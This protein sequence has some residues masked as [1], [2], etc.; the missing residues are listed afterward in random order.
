MDTTSL[1]CDEVW[2]STPTPD[3]LNYNDNIPPKTD[4]SAEYSSTQVSEVDFLICLEKEELY[5]PKKGFLNYLQ[6]QNLIFS[7]FRAI[8]WLIKTCTRFNLSLV[9]LFNAANYLDR[10]ISINHCHEWK[11]WMM[12]LL[13]VACLSVAAKFSETSLPSLHEI[14][15]E[16]L[17]HT[18]EPITIQQMELILL[19]TL[20]WRLSSTTSYSFLELLMTMK[21]DDLFQSSLLKDLL[22]DRVTQLLLQTILDYKMVE[23]RPSIAAISAMW[24]GMEELMPSQSQAYLTHITGFFNHIHKDEIVK[25]R[26]IMLETK[27]VDPVYDCRE[28][29]EKCPSSPV[30]VLLKGGIDGQA[31][32]SI[33][34]IKESESNIQ[35][36]K[37]RRMNR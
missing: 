27:L 36:N 30:T 15:M 25:C 20:K 8:Q 16:G 12:E 2:L 33:F 29:S 31:D 23:C 10:F 1:L 21:M 26:D 18:F 9:A 17:D 7:R 22:L 34:N 6:S 13:S 14:Q 5:L 11:N 37:R 28:N 32:L 35:A 19:N 24:C 3:Y 4:T